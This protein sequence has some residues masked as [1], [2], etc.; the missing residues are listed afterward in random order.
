MKLKNDHRI[1]ANYKSAMA[2]AALFSLFVFARFIPHPPN[3]SPVTAV[4]FCSGLWFLRKS[5]ML[6]LPLLAIFVTDSIIGLYEGV[7][8]TYFAYILI[9]SLGALYASIGHQSKVAKGLYFV[10]SNVAAS[11][12]FFVISNVGVWWATPLYAHNF[13]GLMECFVLA[14]PFYPATLASQVFFASLLQGLVVA[15]LLPSLHRS[16]QLT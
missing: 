10:A 5:W 1:K 14:I 12:I 13:Q 8:F 2:I 11:V 16:E 15:G 4:A 7:A 6:L 3:F 9:F